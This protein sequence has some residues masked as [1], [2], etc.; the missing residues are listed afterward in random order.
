V[1]QIHTAWNQARI[2]IVELPFPTPPEIKGSKAGDKEENACDDTTDKSSNIS[3]T[4]RFVL[5]RDCHEV[6]DKYDGPV[7]HVR[8]D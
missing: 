6:K 4:G 2:L 5:Q 7:D 8:H 1:G 3:T